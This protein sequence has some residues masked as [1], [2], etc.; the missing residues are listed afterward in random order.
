M[1]S[2]I[3]TQKGICTAVQ[4]KVC[5]AWNG[6]NQQKLYPYEKIL[7]MFILKNIN[8]LPIFFLFINSNKLK[9]E[10]E[11]NYFEVKY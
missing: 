10:E 2:R 6:E 7:E 4:S 11:M 9:Y 8:T 3:V 1:G 5:L